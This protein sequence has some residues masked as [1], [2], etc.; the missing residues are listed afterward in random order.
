MKKPSLRLSAHISA[1]A[2]L[3]VVVGSLASL[4]LATAVHAAG[5]FALR[6]HGNS[7]PGVDRVRIPLGPST[8]ADVGASDFTLEFWLKGLAAEN[9]APAIECGANANWRLGNIV[10]DRDRVTPGGRFGLSVAGGRIAF[11][12]STL[13][14]DITLCSLSEI[15]DD[16]WHHVAVE[17]RRADGLIAIFV[18]GL[19]ET[20]QEGPRGNISFRSVSP[21]E[22]CG[23]PCLTDPFLY[24]GGDKQGVGPAFSGG[25]DE[26]RISTIL[27][28]LGRFEPP[29][30]SF[31]ADAATAALYHFDEGTGTVVVDSSKAPDGASHGEILFGGTPPGPEWTLDSPFVGEPPVLLSI[32]I[33]GEGTV[34]TVP[35]G[36]ECKV[37]CFATFPRG[38]AVTL[39][40]DPAPG[41]AFVGWGGDPA[42]DDGEV[43]LNDNTGCLARFVL[44]SDLALTMVSAPTHAAPGDTLRVSFRIRNRGIAPA[45][46]TV[47][48]MYLAVDR[49]LTIG[50]QVAEIPTPG[51]APDEIFDAFADI[52][53][54]ARTPTARY[55]LIISAN[56]DGAAPEAR[57]DNNV[58]RLPLEVG[59]DLVV[60][61]LEAPLILP[62]G[63]TVVIRDTTRND[64][65]VA[66]E[67]SATRF[68]LAASPDAMGGLFLGVREVEPLGPAQESTGETEVTVPLHA[69][70]GLRFVI[71]VADGPRVVDETMEN[72]N[73]S[74]AFAVIVQ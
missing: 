28:Y 73:T 65:Q 61:S 33:D 47:A 43:V 15:L 71:A 55:F 72:N 67:A 25:L 29:A 60:T 12:V 59:P 16:E 52:T 56:A 8:P 44:A 17:R 20:Q 53:I 68:F 46:P 1:V 27:R 32:A 70:T 48:R 11:G 14:E 58:R 22:F 66:V 18:D 9:T 31:V 4:A 34:T 7:A 2:L 64:G 45:E 51:L 10:F 54:P 23:D 35:A 50:F 3:A 69:P 63:G 21:G 6:F 24:M 19:L 74:Q 36:L 40:P 41:Y 30:S 62:R 38:T 39:I 37:N 57:M 42:C 13:T 5:N 49:A 26:V